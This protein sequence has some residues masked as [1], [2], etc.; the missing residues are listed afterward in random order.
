LGFPDRTVVLQLNESLTRAGADRDLV[1]MD[2]QLS[3]YAAVQLVMLA[4]LYPLAEAKK[5]AVFTDFL[6][7]R[8]FLSCRSPGV[9]ALKTLQ[10]FKMPGFSRIRIIPNG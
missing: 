3:C 8:R 5:I 6:Y 4:R 10:M 7:P 9:V 2:S 1:T